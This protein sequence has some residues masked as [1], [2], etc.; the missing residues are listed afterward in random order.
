MSY[1]VTGNTSNFGFEIRGSFPLRTT[2]KNR[3]KLAKNLQ[4]SKISCIFASSI[5]KQESSLKKLERYTVSLLNC[6]DKAVML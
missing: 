1:G 6:E 5:K 4:V 2:K 3:K